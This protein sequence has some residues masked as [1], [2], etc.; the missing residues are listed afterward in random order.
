MHAI[1]KKTN[2]KRHYINVF[3]FP[4]QYFCHPIYQEKKKEKTKRNRNI[5]H[6]ENCE[7][8]AVMH[9]VLGLYKLNKNSQNNKLKFQQGNKM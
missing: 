6:W 3:Y 4:S 5:P 9:Y 8:C 2:H 7:L 1:E